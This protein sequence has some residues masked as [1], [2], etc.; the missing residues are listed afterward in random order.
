[1]CSTI[2]LVDGTD[3]LHRVGDGGRIAWGNHSR[4]APNDVAAVSFPTLAL[5]PRDSSAREG[6]LSHKPPGD[7]G[8]T[9]LLVRARGLETGEDPRQAG[10][11]SVTV[12]VATGV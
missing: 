1:M 12:R 11:E 10:R 9:A 7:S 2:R 8:V 3:H 4:G 5:R 6:D